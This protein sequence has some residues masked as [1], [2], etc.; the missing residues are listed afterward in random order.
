ML[1]IKIHTLILR[2]VPYDS[3]RKART[4][5]CPS[6]PL[7]ASFRIQEGMQRR[8]L[9][10]LL[11]MGVLVLQQPKKITEEEEFA[12]LLFTSLLAPDI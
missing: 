12:A 3:G 9:H 11:T 2:Y 10:Y 5:V 1:I 7:L 8:L 6:F 4:L